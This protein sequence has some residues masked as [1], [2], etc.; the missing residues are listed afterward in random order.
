MGDKDDLISEILY[1][2][3]GNDGIKIINSLSKPATDLQLH[4]VTQISITKVRSTLNALHKFN[5]V[6]YYSSRDERKGWFKYTW[7]LKHYCIE[8]SIR[9][10]LISKVMKLKRDFQE[11]NQV[12]FFKCENGCIRVN[13]TEAYDENFRCPRCNGVL[14]PVDSIAESRQI[15]ME[16]S[17][18]KKMVKLLGPL[19][20]SLQNVG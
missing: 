9:N 18:I 10:F 5:I 7:E 16:I 11:I 8:P 13:F 4:D 12:D 3:V 1:E 20:V 6:S 17:Q 15:K 14:K 2:M 19:P